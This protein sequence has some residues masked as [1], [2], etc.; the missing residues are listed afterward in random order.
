MNEKIK[1]LLFFLLFGLMGCTQEPVPM[2]DDGMRT[3]SSFVISYAGANSSETAIERDLKDIWVF[4][5]SNETKRVVMTSK[6]E[7]SLDKNS[8]KVDLY[9]SENDSEEQ[10]YMLVMIA[11]ADRYIVLDSKKYIGMSYQQLNE[12]LVNSET[13]TAT[14]FD[15]IET[16]GIVMWGDTEYLT[17]YTKQN[18][19]TVTLSRAIA[20][21]TIGVGTPTT[22]VNGAVTWDGKKIDALGTPTAEDVKFTLTSINLVRTESKYSFTP[23]F[24]GAGAIKYNDATNKVTD[25]SVPVNSITNEVIDAFQYLVP[26]DV[27]GRADI[28]LPESRLI[29]SGDRYTHFAFVVGGRY[30]LDAEDSYYRIDV[31][32]SGGLLNILRN[33]NYQFNIK[34]VSK[35]GQPTV[36]DAYNDPEPP[37]DVDVKIVPWVDVNILPPTD[38]IGTLTV[39]HLQPAKDVKI[40]TFP[41]EIDLSTVSLTGNKTN[42][43]ISCEIIEMSDPNFF[44]AAKI[45]N[46]AGDEVTEIGVEPLKVSIFTIE[47]SASQLSLSKGTCRYKIKVGGLEYISSLI[48]FDYF[49]TY[50]YAMDRNTPS[51][52]ANSY[53]LSKDSN[54]EHLFSLERIDDY[55]GN[56]TDDVYGGAFGLTA[57]LP[58]T[59]AENPNLKA[60]ILWADFEYDETAFLVSTDVT[61]KTLHLKTGTI[62]T[63][64]GSMI[65][66]VTKEDGITILW[67]WHMWFTDIKVDPK[68]ATST[69]LPSGV[70]IMDRNLGAKSKDG[71]DTETFGLAYQWGRK[72][73]FIFIKSKLTSNSGS[74][75]KSIANPRVFYTVPDA[76]TNWVREGPDANVETSK[77]W[78]NSLNGLTIG[79]KTIF[80][81]CPRGWKVPWGESWSGLTTINTVRVSTPY[82]G[83]KYKLST[84]DPTGVNCFLPTCGIL[85]RTTSDYY[86]KGNESSYWGGTFTKSNPWFMYTNGGAI[87]PKR[88]YTSAYGVNVRPVLE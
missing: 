53:I 55:W 43:P 86:A 81:P 2:L 60:K 62:P 83:F 26:A 16:D 49:N 24:D 9:K 1:I 42:V 25:C 69:E 37:I 82:A 50:H 32:K 36:E 71:P 27:K 67:S 72:D 47:P 20:R 39:K 54:K 59:I 8:F 22:D 29:V 51:N 23:G 15:N 48:P 41:M 78:N 38:H 64:G 79:V 13:I 28:Y 66:A 18:L 7:L 11:N 4:A 3:K 6:G 44:L 58:N 31:K 56:T 33:H 88:H 17:I 57:P 70:F 61:Y 10:K 85:S 73:P 63:N 21:M 45:I 77:R 46:N 74:I 80:D 76:N 68:E 75:K 5:I 65:I 84:T 14:A 30:Y 87:D 19:P 34:S 12:S 40:T 52:R 35:S